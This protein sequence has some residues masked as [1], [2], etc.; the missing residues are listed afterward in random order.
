MKKLPLPLSPP[1]KNSK[2]FFL[3]DDIFIKKNSHTLSYDRESLVASLLV[4]FTRYD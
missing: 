4:F 3:F 1:L 2:I